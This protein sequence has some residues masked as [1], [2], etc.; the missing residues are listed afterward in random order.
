MSRLEYAPDVHGSAWVY[1]TVFGAAAVYN[2]AFGLWAALFP[3]AFFDLVQIPRPSYPAIWGCLGM[4]V[5]LYGVLYAYAARH[6][7]RAFPLIAVGLAGKIL[8]PIGWV[9]AVAGGEWPIRTFTLIVFNDL[10]WWIPFGMFLL[11][12]TAAAV[13]LKR[14]TPYVCAVLNGLAMA[15][16]AIILRPGTEV[17]ADVSQ[18]IAYISEHTS[19]WRAGWIVWI[20]AALSLA[21]FY[22]WW[23]AHTR[24]PLAARAAFALVTAGLICDLLAESFYIGWF[25]RDYT[26][27]A[28]LGLFLTGA[29]A[30]GLYTAAGVTLTI[31]SPQLR[32]RVRSWAWAVW[33]AGVALSICALAESPVGIAISTTVLMALFVP[34]TAV[35]ARAIREEA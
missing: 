7:D 9:V 1:R 16:M 13:R 3:S 11:E 32:G 2:V 5:G 18:R 24:R 35:A 31:A 15:A 23:G 4:V 26:R 20:A 19:E 8:G 10:I 14:S 6:L 27:L 17:V 21:S 33:I 30:N 22:A 12:G 25:P 28:P 34:W 29:V